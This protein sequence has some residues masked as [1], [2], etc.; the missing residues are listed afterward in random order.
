[1]N[2]YCKYNVNRFS[3]KFDGYNHKISGLVSLGDSNQGLFGCC[4]DIQ[5]CNLNITDIYFASGNECN[6]ETNKKLLVGYSR[7]YGKVS[8]SSENVNQVIYISNY[9]ELELGEVG[10]AND[11]IEPETKDS[12]VIFIWGAAILLIVSAGG[13]FGYKI[14]K[15][16]K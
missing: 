9:R 6:E 16:R 11:I 14:Y 2:T 10:M 3:G 13:A 15:K 8:V 1:M 7:D 12:K 5:I 4:S